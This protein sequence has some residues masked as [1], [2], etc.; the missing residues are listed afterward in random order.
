MGALLTAWRIAKLLPWRYILAVAAVAVLG[1][2]IE[3]LDAK[4][5]ADETARQEAAKEAERLAKQW[6]DR[7][8]AIQA[9]TDKLLASARSD[10]DHLRKRV[11]DAAQVPAGDAGGGPGDTSAAAG[12]CALPEARAVVLRAAGSDLVQWAADAD[13]AATAAVACNAAYDAIK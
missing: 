6:E 8:D 9:E 3:A 5:A 11:L 10:N 1:P 13:R 7:R 4:V 2:Q 12:Q